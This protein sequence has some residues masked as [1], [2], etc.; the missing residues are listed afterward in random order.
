MLYR[1]SYTCLL[2]TNDPTPLPNAVTEMY[3]YLS[4]Y[5]C[6]MIYDDDNDVMPNLNRTR[7]VKW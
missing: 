2:T 4:L 6:R 1:V 7:L 3:I 5:M